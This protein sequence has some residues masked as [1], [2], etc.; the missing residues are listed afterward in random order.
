MPTNARRR[1]VLGSS[2]KF[3]QTTSNRSRLMSKHKKS[4]KG[5]IST[6]L[7]VK[8]LPNICP[9]ML[10]YRHTNARR[11]A[12]LGSSF[13]FN[14][15]T[16]NR[17]RLMSKHQKSTRG[18]RITLLRVKNNPITAQK[19]EETRGPRF[20]VQILPNHFYPIQSD[21]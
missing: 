4:T 11:R 19:R 10:Y 8:K 15:T 13:K 6:P 14:Q 2:F 5:S 9:K 20:F 21:E 17:S 16:S 3:N 18:S 7:R 1:A 12:V